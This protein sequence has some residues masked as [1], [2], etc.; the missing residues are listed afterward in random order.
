[1]KKQTLET[2]KKF[3]MGFFLSDWKKDYDSVL[4]DLENGNTDDILIWEA[5]ENTYTPEEIANEI[6]SMRIQI[7]QIVKAEVSTRK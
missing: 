6:D 1:M 7:E 3:A 2:I 5:M 4:E